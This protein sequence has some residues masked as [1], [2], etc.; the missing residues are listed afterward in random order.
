MMKKEDKASQWIAANIPVTSILLDKHN[1]RIA[2]MEDPNIGQSTLIKLFW[3]NYDI[4]EIIKSIEISGLYKHE[5]PVL[6]KDSAQEG[7]YIVIE[8]NRRLAAL[9]YYKILS[10][11]LLHKKSG[12]LTF[13][14]KLNPK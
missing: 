14:R 7:R 3:E 1:L 5:V 9:K 12:L 10:S 4:K 13:H 8:G 2:W 6:I 11:F